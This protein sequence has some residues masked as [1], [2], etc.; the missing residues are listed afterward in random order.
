ML[1][2]RK[3]NEN[4][5]KKDF[6]KKEKNKK[7]QVLKHISNVSSFNHLLVDELD[8]VIFPLINSKTFVLTKKSRSILDFIKNKKISGL[9]IFCSRLNKKEY[10]KLKNIDIV[11]F[12][13]SNRVLEI[14][15]TIHNDLTS[16]FKTKFENNH[17]KFLAFIYEEKF[18][19]I[20]GSGN[21]SV[22]ARN[23]FYII[24][25]DKELYF[26]ILK[27]YQDA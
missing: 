22:N 1:K 13:L 19:I 11:G 21:P 16:N 6:F 12:G 17:C 10:E 4:A 24:S 3:V 27:M 25:E 20:E 23:E 8:S 26:K 14:N 18:F 9:I 5:V 7:K 15:P 2:P